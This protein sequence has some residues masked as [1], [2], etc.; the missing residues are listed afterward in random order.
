M[1]V[2]LNV[3]DKSVATFLEDRLLSYKPNDRNGMNGIHESSAY[4]LMRDE[5]FF[6]KDC[7]I[8]VGET[9]KIELFD[10]AQMSGK[11]LNNIYVYKAEQY[12]DVAI[13]MVLD[14]FTIEPSVG[15]K[16]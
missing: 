3:K 15:Q 2:K 1:E 8:A 4:H 13:K 5:M 16:V 7:G 11:G 6:K 10:R 12:D 14:N 9:V